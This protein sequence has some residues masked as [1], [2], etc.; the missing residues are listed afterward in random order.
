MVAIP[1]RALILDRG[2]WWVMVH[3]PHGNHPRQVT[4]GPARG[5]NTFITHGLPAGSQVIVNNAYLLFHASI[6]EH[7]QSAN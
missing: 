7:Y 2:K 4:P 6:A 3:T 5:W 1:T